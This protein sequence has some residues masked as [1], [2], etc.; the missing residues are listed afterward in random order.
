MENIK[1]VIFD[2]ANVVGY[3]DEEYFH[4]FIELNGGNK[5]P[6]VKVSEEE[7]AEFDRAKITEKDF[8]EDIAEKTGLDLPWQVLKEN[9]QKILR[10]D[11]RIVKLIKKISLD[12]VLLSDMD[13]TIKKQI[14]K[15]L[16]LKDLFNKS[17]F[18]CDQGKSK[19]DEEILERICKNFEVEPSNVLFIDDDPRNIK[20]AE[21]FGLNVHQY[22]DYSTLTSDL[23]RTDII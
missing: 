23:K 9:H 11:Y 16:H 7:N 8:W 17:I 3:L 19:M 12:K 4:K 14:K 22:T 10:I 18:S 15:E 5:K 1:L 20:K 6:F 2:F 21:E 13:I